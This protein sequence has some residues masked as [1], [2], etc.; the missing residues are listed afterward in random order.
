M[1]S[2]NNINEKEKFY[3]DMGLILGSERPSCDLLNTC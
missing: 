3:K 2:R 1:E